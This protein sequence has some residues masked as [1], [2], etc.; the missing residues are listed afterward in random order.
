MVFSE[1]V[2]SL[3]RSSVWSPSNNKIH[4]KHTNHTC[5][6][7]RYVFPFRKW[8]SFYWFFGTSWNWTSIWLPADLPIFSRSAEGE[9]SIFSVLV[10]SIMQA[11][12]SWHASKQSSLEPLWLAASNGVTHDGKP[13]STLPSA[14]SQ[15]TSST[16]TLRGVAIRGPRVAKDENLRSISNIT[17][18]WQGCNPAR[19]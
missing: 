11:H 10:I 13:P 4:N 18:D 2:T 1:G 5:K 16:C 8:E 14:A 12:D 19:V 17:V 6:R 7:N 9:R 15:L 3:N